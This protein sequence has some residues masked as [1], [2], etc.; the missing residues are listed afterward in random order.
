MYSPQVLRVEKARAEEQR[1][2]EHARRYEGPLSTVV[3]FVAERATKA[4]EA[5]EERLIAERDPVK[6][7]ELARADAEE[8]AEVERLGREI[9]S[10]TALSAMKL[11]SITAP[12]TAMRAE[13]Q[14]RLE[15]AK[16]DPYSGLYPDWFSWLL[17]SRADRV[18]D[19]PELMDDPALDQGQ[20][21]MDA[22]THY[23]VLLD[24]SSPPDPLTPAVRGVT[25]LTAPH[26][27]DA[28]GVTLAA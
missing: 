26:G 4:R 24:A 1:A 17:A 20:Q 23:A 18:A 28:R 11:V 27:P 12:L 7:V 2:I 21:R 10:M 13:S 15:A 8:R 5:A 22:E 9:K 6:R 25:T 14:A 16:R 19:W 3:D